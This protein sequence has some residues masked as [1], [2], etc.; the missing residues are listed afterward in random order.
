MAR[1]SL[2]RSLYRA[3]RISSNISAVASGKPSRVARR[4][5]NI[6]VGRALGRAGVWRSLWK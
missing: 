6:V 1:S 5:K 4:G 3:A 2:T